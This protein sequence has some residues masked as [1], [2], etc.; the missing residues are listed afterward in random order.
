MI[1]YQMAGNDA[2]HH[3]F[4]M[5]STDDEAEAMPVHLRRYALSGSGFTIGQPDSYGKGASKR[6][7]PVATIYP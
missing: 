2:C 4:I 7:K 6:E 5:W 1:L 3:R